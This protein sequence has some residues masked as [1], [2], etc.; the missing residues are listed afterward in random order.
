MAFMTPLR[1]VI[2]VPL[3]DLKVPFL[4]LRRPDSRLAASSTNKMNILVIKLG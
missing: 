2:D 1:P 4:L 3:L